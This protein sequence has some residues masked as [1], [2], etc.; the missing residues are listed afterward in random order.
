[1]PISPAAR[2]RTPAR[3]AARDGDSDLD[4]AHGPIARHSGAERDVAAPSLHVRAHHARV[5]YAPGHTHVD[6]HDLG[7][8]E[9]RHA[10]GAR[11]PLAH[12]ARDGS[13]HVLPALR[14]AF[15]QRPRCRRRTPRAHG[16]TRP[17]RRSPELQRYTRRRLQSRPI[18]PRGARWSPTRRTRR[19]ERT[20]PRAQSGRARLR[21]RAGATRSALDFLANAGKRGFGCFSHAVSSLQTTL[22]QT[23][24]RAQRRGFAG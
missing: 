19:R 6:G 10:T 23:R 3:A 21:A 9:R 2:R 5:F 12:V 15:G 13:R 7:T 22:R 24:T 1:M 17:P 20:R 14:H 16:E 8:R 11:G 18:P 4:R